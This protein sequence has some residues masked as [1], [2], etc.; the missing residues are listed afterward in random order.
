MG[1][2][3]HRLAIVVVVTLVL[4]AG[5]ALGGLGVATADEDTDCTF[6]VE[7]T[8]ATGETVVVDEEPETVVTLA[9][10][11]AQTMWE[12][13]AEEK[14][15][16][17]SMHAMFLEGADERVDV[18]ADPMSIDIEVVVDLEPDLVI[19]PNVTPRD[20][21][22]ELRDLGVTVYHAHTSDDLDDV[23]EKTLTIGSLVGE[24]SGA[25]E[26]VTDMQ[27]R[28]NEI[29]ERLGEID[30]R[31]LVF[32]EMGDG[33][34]A[35]GG[36]FQHVVLE[37]AGVTNLANEVGIVYWE[38]VSGE[39]LIDSEPEWIV[40]TDSI[41]EDLF[42]DAVFDTPAWDLGQVVTVDAQNFS[43][44]AP[45]VIDAIEELHVAVHGEFIEE[46]PTPTPTSTP[47]PTPTPA[48]PTPTPS[49]TPTPDESAQPIPGFTAIISIL[50]LAMVTG[51][52]VLRRR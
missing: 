44:P 37:R 31:P 49:P 10:S 22:G 28:L 14:V 7:V 34:T 36:T 23:M 6:P 15:V 20:E 46:T 16:G 9:P 1:E 40:H 5:L 24:C 51:A 2:R 19:A 26:T 35:G 4:T 45:R 30:E 43:Q 18:S 50:A 52:L 11:A 21:I 48:E 13:G 47:T 12:I 32:Y 39:I 38:P 25:T 42:L 29:D 3:I 8:D 17:V 33:F 27:E 41:G